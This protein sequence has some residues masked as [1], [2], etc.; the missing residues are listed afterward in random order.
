MNIKEE[1]EKLQSELESI[2]VR[3]AEIQGLLKEADEEKM[4]SLRD[5]LSALDKRSKAIPD[6]IKALETKR[7]EEAALLF[8]QTKK[9][10]QERK[11]NMN[12]DD[13][14]K[15]RAELGEKLMRGESIKLQTRDILISSTGITNP[16]KTENE[17]RPG[18]FAGYSFIDQ[19]DVI[20]AKGNTSWV[21]PIE[22]AD[23]TAG[24]GTDGQ[25][26][27]NS[28]PVFKKATLT[29]QPINVVTYVSKHISSYTPTDF[30]NK[31]AE[32]AVR[33]V[34]KKVLDYIVAKATTGAADDSTALYDNVSA[35][36]TTIDANFLRAMVLGYGASDTV[37]GGTCLLM[38]KATL[39]ALGA[40]RGTNEKQ[41]LYSIKFDDESN[42]SGIISEGGVSARF[43]IVDS[44]DST[45]DTIICMK[46]KA[47]SLAQ[48]EE[49]TVSVSRDEQFSKG[50]L[51]VLA[52]TSIGGNLNA[53]H[54]AEF[55]TI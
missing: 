35:T 12:L 42:D 30:Y 52:E 16:A 50:L 45:N 27:N 4:A 39:V 48:F 25:A 29:A 54:G 40:V 7:E 55:T 46:P 14:L 24:N 2:G 6:E 8:E 49:I 19:V 28:D 22:G 36:I 20:D 37:V 1:I 31:V 51:S 41:A 34:R 44:L 5:E 32:K 13:L 43:Y 18:F 47:F 17:V 33:A 3:A 38:C 11:I 15:Q 10:E 21:L 53:L 23:Q 9:A 26:A